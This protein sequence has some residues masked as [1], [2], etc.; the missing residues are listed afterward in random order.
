VVGFSWERF[1][2]EISLWSGGSFASD[3]KT[4]LLPVDFDT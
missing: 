4:V 3:L 1:A 2:I